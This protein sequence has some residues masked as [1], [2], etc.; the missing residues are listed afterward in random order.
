MVAASV[1]IAIISV[2]AGLM[3]ASRDGFFATDI[4]ARIKLIS[5]MLHKDLRRLKVDGK[6]AMETAALFHGLGWIALEV[7]SSDWVL[8]TKAAH[9]WW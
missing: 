4:D 6:R 5:G 2:Y 8:H 7:R 9:P 3:L 1:F